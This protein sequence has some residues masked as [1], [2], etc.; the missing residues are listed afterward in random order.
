MSSNL[1]YQATVSM[2]GDTD[3]ITNCKALLRRAPHSLQVDGEWAEFARKHQ[4]TIVLSDKDYDSL[5]EVDTAWTG[6]VAE[7]ANIS[8]IEFARYANALSIRRD[9]ADIVIV[10]NSTWETEA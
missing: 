5:Y 9:K 10:P 8:A 2:L 4:R 1:L 7:E 3:A 6:E